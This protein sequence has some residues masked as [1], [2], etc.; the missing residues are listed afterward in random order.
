MSTD[1]RFDLSTEAI[2]SSW[3]DAAANAPKG[4]KGPLKRKAGPVR[5]MPSIH[6]LDVF[7]AALVGTVTCMIG[8]Y[9]WFELERASGELHPWAAL[10]LGASIALAVRSGGGR[11]DHQ[12]RAVLS[13]GIYVVGMAVVLFLLGRINYI[14][15]Y[16]T[17]PDFLDFEQH[18]YHSRLT[19]FAS[20]AGW[21][22]GAFATVL[23]SY[24]TRKR[25]TI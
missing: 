21:L 18:L 7:T 11:H 4:E 17:T 13:L 22:S 6:S 23:L 12:L 19:N 20:V 9:L 16:G 24:L 5:L 25:T 14:E 2:P 10:A 1:Q 3:H 15:L 8:G